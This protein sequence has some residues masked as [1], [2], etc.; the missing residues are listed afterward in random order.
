MLKKKYSRY[1]DLFQLMGSERRLAI[2]DTLQ[3]YPSAS[4]GFLAEASELS[5]HA[6]SKHMRLL[7]DAGLITCQAEG[8]FRMYTLA[9]RLPKMVQTVLRQL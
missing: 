7:E 9:R 3:K 8:T 5:S 1:A 6:T 4:V 2:L